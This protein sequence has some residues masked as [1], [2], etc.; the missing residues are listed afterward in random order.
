[1]DLSNDEKALYGE[2]AVQIAIRM[3][4]VVFDRRPPH[5]PPPKDRFDIKGRVVEHG[6][7]SDFEA[8]CRMLQRLNV[9][10]P[11]DT[12]ETPLDDETAWAHLFRVKFD[13]PEL[14]EHA[15]GALPDSAP[16]L[17]EAIKTFLGL[18]IDYGCEVSACRD[19]F[20]VYPD[21][22]RAFDLFERCGYVERVDGM[23]AWTDKVAPVMRELDVWNEDLTCREDSSEVARMWQTMPANIR[24]AIFRCGPVEVSA[25]ARV[26][27]RFWYYGAWHRTALDAADKRVTLRRGAMRKAKALEKQSL[28]PKAGFTEGFR[29]LFTGQAT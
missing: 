22:E 7:V 21:F 13:L 12:D 1:M 10:H 17:S 9:A 5:Y 27:A 15:R 24:T 28:E 29:L 19:P 16:T 4:G 2:L 14:R 20:A 11:L 26:I 6:S 23:V 18:T 25:L 8:G 3:G